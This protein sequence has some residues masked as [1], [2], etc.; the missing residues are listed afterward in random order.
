MWRLRTR[1]VKKGMDTA[2]FCALTDVCN[3][4]RNIQNG[5]NRMRR[6][7]YNLS[8]YLE[9]IYLTGNFQRFLCYGEL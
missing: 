6:R 7:L 4:R 1:R 9:Q 8:Y 2:G 3:M 5:G